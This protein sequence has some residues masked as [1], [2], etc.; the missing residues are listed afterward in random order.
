MLIDFDCYERDAKKD[1]LHNAI[2]CFLQ[3]DKF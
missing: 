1:Y 3:K 2:I